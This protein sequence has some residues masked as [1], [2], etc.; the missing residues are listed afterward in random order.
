MHKPRLLSIW[1]VLLLILTGCEEDLLAPEQAMLRGLRADKTLTD[2]EGN[3]YRIGF[4][5]A[6][7]INQNPFIVKRDPAG[8]QLWK[9]TYEDTPVD[10]RGVWIAMDGQGKLWAVFT[11]DGGSNLT[12]AIHRKA[13]K[14]TQ[15]FS[16][17][18]MNSYGS[19][20]G[21]KASVIARID[22][23]D[24]K[25][26]KGTFVAAR[27]GNGRTNTLQIQ[28]FGVRDGQVIFEASTA[29]WPP[30]KGRTYAPFPSITDADRVSGAFKLVYAMDA[31][32]TRI[33]EAWLLRE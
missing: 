27:L 31:N 28:R 2:R 25:I 30:G 29:A 19:G 9:M 22:P 14:N 8:K 6:S 24:G 32:L 12:G 18:F 5:Q 33:E 23:K 7:A 17:V 15:A 21:P 1:I 20:G 26:E 16:G 10:G 3:Q 13:V 4:D 11:V